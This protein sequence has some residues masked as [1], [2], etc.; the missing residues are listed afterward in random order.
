MTTQNFTF[1]I[2]ETSLRSLKNNSRTDFISTIQTFVVN[3]RFNARITYNIYGAENLPQVYFALQL[4]NFS[5][6]SN[7]EEFLI[8]RKLSLDAKV[9]ISNYTV[10]Y[11]C[12]ISQVYYVLARK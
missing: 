6:R 8:L 11:I 9:N 7:K 1:K 5:I 4:Q 2:E 10:I 3:V 12:I